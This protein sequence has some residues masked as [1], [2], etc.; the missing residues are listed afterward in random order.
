MSLKEAIEDRV[1]VHSLHIMAPMI[2]KL[3]DLEE[4]F[5][6]K[7]G[8]LGGSVH[9]LGGSVHD[10]HRDMVLFK[11]QISEFQALRSGVGLVFGIIIALS[12]F[13]GD[14]DKNQ[15]VKWLFNSQMVLIGSAASVG[16]VGYFVTSR[17]VKDMNRSSK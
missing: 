2:K 6:K 12:Q 5:D 1:E 3:G 10:L 16:L 13:L 8:D 9:D 15:L 7:F 17:A 14:G 11:E 4:S